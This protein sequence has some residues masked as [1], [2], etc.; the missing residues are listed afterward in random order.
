MILVI[1]CVIND[2]KSS[3]AGYF[4]HWCSSF[5]VQC[6]VANSSINK[7]SANESEVLK[8]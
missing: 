1:Q 2:E 6:S 4:I 3:Y 7:C 8:R 5:F